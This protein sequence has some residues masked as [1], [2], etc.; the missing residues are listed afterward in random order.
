MA[1]SSSSPLSRTLRI[2]IVGFG[3]FG[4]FL[5]TTMMKQ[6][7]T[8]TAT[9]RSDHSQLCARLGISFFR[10]MNE[11][12]E[13]ENDVI[14]L[15][16]SILSLTEV[17][18][19]LPLHCL[20]RPTLFADVLS[21]KEG[22]REVLLQ[23]LPEESDVLCTHPM[24]GPESG[25]DGWNGL[26]FMYERVRI[27]DEATCSSFLHIFESEGC[28]M[29]EMSC[30]EHDKLAARS[31]FLTHTIGRILSEM[32]IES[33]PI[34]TKGFQTLIQLKDSTIRDSFDLYSGLF[35]HNKFAKQ[36]L[37]NLALAFEKVKQKLEEMNEKSDL[38]MQPL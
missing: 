25:R 15:C 37:N 24:F 29:L 14:M 36:E 16:T 31:Q 8:L 10:G 22:P 27:R 12:I 17:L 13:A 7:H 32:E 33:T 34:D 1:V 21:V 18:K 35:V 38:S 6:G 4:Q 23:V 26:A 2:G 11:F 28:R 30:E 19:S 3:P 20:K 5:A 9:S